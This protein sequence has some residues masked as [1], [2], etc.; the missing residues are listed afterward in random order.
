MATQSSRLIPEGNEV[1][2]PSV[3]DRPSRLMPQRLVAEILEPRARE[4]FEMMRDKLRQ[5]GMFEV[6]VARHRADRGRL[7]PARHVGRR[8][9][10][11]APLGAPVL[12]RTAGQDAVDFVRTRVRHSLGHGELRPARPNRARAARDRWGYKIESDVGRK[13]GA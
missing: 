8:G 2:V 13:R 12:A 11:A 4:L 5:S 10:R 1:E 7:A 6:C 3:G 9:I